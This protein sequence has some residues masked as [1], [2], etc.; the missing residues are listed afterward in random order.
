MYLRLR[1][2]AA[3]KSWATT[4]YA[5]YGCYNRLGGEMDAFWGLL[6]MVGT[7]Y[8]SEVRCG[9]VGCPISCLIMT[10]TSFDFDILSETF[11]A[12][13]IKSCFPPELF[14]NRITNEQT[15][16][17]EVRVSFLSPI[18]SSTFRAAYL[19]EVVGRGLDC[20]RSYSTPKLCATIKY[21]FL[22]W[23]AFNTIRVRC[24]AG[25]DPISG[26]IRTPTRFP[27]TR[28]FLSAGET[29][30][31]TMNAAKNSRLRKNPS[32]R[33]YFSGEVVL[34]IQ[35]IHDSLPTL[36][37]QRQWDVIKFSS[38][39]YYSEMKCGQATITS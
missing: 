18:S 16:D 2:E 12:S 34:A 13:P 4:L 17:T 20:T 37:Q 32:M 22:I 10:T 19:P 5:C 14:Q 3:S 27:T 31:W 26:L 15:G 8:D 9:A 39:T 23:W 35:S 6:E 28:H 7:L 33:L 25:F 30:N 11:A 36:A 38:A 24:G 29:A 21:A 1:R